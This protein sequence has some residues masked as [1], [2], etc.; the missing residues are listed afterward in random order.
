MPEI[1]R[2][3]ILLIILARYLMAHKMVGSVTRAVA[4]LV[5]FRWFGGGAAWCSAQLALLRKSVVRVHRGPLRGLEPPEIQS[6]QGGLRLSGRFC[7][8]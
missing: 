1:R 4:A 7:T 5:F 6:R 3:P 8:P 2:T